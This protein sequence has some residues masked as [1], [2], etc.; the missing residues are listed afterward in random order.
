MLLGIAGTYRPHDSIDV[1]F[2]ADGARRVVAL[3]PVES[4]TDVG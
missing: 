2:T 1:V 4:E 3:A